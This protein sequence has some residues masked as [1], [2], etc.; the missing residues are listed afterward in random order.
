M[1]TQPKILIVDDE[2]NVMRALKRTFGRSKMTIQDAGSG[3]Q[4]LE[5][6]ASNDFNLVISDLRM[7]EMNG[8]EFLSLA[9]DLH[10]DTS[11]ILLSG[12]AG[13]EDLGE[14]LNRCRIVYFVTKPWIKEGFV[15]IAQRAIKENIRMRLIEENIRLMKRKL[16]ELDD[17]LDSFPGSLF[18]WD[19]DTRLVRSN[20]TNELV[21]R[22]SYNIYLGIK[23]EYMIRNLVNSG[24]IPLDP[25]E[26]ESYIRKCLQKF[27]QRSGVFKQKWRYGRHFAIYH[28]EIGNGGTVSFQLDI[29][30]TKQS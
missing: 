15:E 18:I 13:Q 20:R 5:L 7:P 1:K 10:P 28:R 22:D 30:R 21:S 23:Y 9:K 17:V 25:S 12:H 26:R 19:E 14:A 8:V 11:Q 6:M 2:V 16:L 24:L 29:T 4:A 27:S 3:K